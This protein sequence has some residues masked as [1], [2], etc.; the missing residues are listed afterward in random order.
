M[1]RN[2]LKGTGSSKLTGLVVGKDPN[3]TTGRPQQIERSRL[4]LRLCHAACAVLIGC[5]WFFSVRMPLA[6][7][8]PAALTCKQ[9]RPLF[10]G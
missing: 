7:G 2:K 8:G 4:I 1:S 9:A 3:T 5:S 10:R 6:H